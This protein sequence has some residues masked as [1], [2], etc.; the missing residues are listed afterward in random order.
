MLALEQAAAAVGMPLTV[1]DVAA[2]ERTGVYRY[3]LLVSRPDLHVGW[4]GDALPG[5]VAGLVDQLRGAVR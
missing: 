2:D 1:I 3:K 4:R 5:D